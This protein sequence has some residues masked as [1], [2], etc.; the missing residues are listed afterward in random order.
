MPPLSQKQKHQAL[1]Q[2]RSGV[3]TRNVDTL[4]DMSQSSKAHMRKDV[5]SEIEGQRGGCPKPL[6]D[7]DIV[8]LL[9][10]KVDLEVHLQ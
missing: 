1:V 10:L 2:L 8:L 6:A 5:R 9:V 3:S 4:V 7:L